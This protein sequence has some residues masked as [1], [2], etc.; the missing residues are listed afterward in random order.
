VIKIKT[1]EEIKNI[2]KAGEILSEVAEV[3]RKHIKVGVTTKELDAIAEQEFDKRGVVSAFKGYRGFPASI[4]SSVNE[5]VVHGIPGE[6]KLSEGDLLS[7]DLGIKLDGYYA[8]MAFTQAVGKI[9]PELKRLVNI[10]KEALAKGIRQAKIDRRVYDISHA[11]Q[12]Y[13]EAAGFSVV[14]EFVGH[15]IGRELHEEPQI[16]NFGRPN[17]GEKITEGMVFA[18]EPMVNMGGWEVDILDNGWTAVTKDKM[19]S[20]HFEHTVAVLKDGPRILT[21]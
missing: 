21:Q 12:S 5:E 9:K 19:P 8:D 6:R 14:R 13:V 16:P 4:C 3:L 1:K 15:G 11:I 20:C 7:I 18:I 17:T 10:T 2:S